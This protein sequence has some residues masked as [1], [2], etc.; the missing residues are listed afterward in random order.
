MLAHILVAK[1]TMLLV[2]EER[3]GLLD[4]LHDVVQVCMAAP[5]DASTSDLRTSNVQ[6]ASLIPNLREMFGQPIFGHLHVLVRAT[7]SGDL[8]HK[9]GELE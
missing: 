6:S 7:Y 1:A 8:A 2:S 9:G 3:D 5:R 4:C